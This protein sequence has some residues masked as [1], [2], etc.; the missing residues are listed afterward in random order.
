MKTLRVLVITRQLPDFDQVIHALSEVPDN[1]AEDGYGSLCRDVAEHSKE[2]FYR[3]YPEFR[4][5]TF[6]ASV[7]L[8]KTR[9]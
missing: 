2:T 5:A 7:H 6:R 4:Q 8:L 9:S 1:V 3:K